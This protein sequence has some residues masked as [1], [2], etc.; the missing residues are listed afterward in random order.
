MKIVSARVIKVDPT[1]VYDLTVA[2]YH[3]F[4]LGVGCIVHNSKDISDSFAG[5]VSGLTMRSEI[6]HSYGINPSEIPAYLTSKKENM[7]EAQKGATDETSDYL[8]VGTG[9]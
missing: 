6:W 1:N 4:K 8:K 3:N 2:S 9:I 7:K 5:V